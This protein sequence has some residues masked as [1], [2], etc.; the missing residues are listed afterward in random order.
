MVEI[1]LRLLPTATMRRKRLQPLISEVFRACGLLP[2]WGLAFA[3]VETEFCPWKIN[4]TH[5]DGRRGGAWGL[6]QMTLAT[7]RSLG[8]NGEPPELLDVERNTQL[9]AKLIRE[10]AHRKDLKGL[11]DVACAYNS[12]HSY[13]TAPMATKHHDARA[14]ARRVVEWQDKYQSYGVDG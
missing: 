5:G 10:L 1:P 8:F 4:Q 13:A 6:F 3:M 7:A 9:A 2:S 11:R 14:Y 12:N